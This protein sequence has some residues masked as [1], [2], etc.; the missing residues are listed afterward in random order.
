MVPLS[1]IPRL[2]DSFLAERGLC[3]T[4]DLLYGMNNVF[5]FVSEFGGGGFK[6]GSGPERLLTLYIT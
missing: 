4:V 1:P 2:I 3:A 6:L 5:T